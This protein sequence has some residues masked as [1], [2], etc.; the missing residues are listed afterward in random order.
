MKR[1]YLTC[2]ELH[3]IAVELTL[4]SLGLVGVVLFY[5]SI[6]MEILYITLI[7]GAMYGTLLSYQIF[8]A[9]KI[10]KI[11]IGELII[12]ITLLAVP[13]LIITY[14][15]TYFDNFTIA[16][17]FISSVLLS[18]GFCLLFIR[19]KTCFK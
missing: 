13:F 18:G 2:K 3:E 9:G 7:L 15:V 4:L 14:L 12:N 10:R 16:I 6:T 17:L 5:S 8:K 1:K 19:W 11:G